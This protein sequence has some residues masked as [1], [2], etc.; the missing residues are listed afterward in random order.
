MAVIFGVKMLNWSKSIL[1]DMHFIQNCPETFT[2]RLSTG[3][4]WKERLVLELN[5]VWNFS[6]SF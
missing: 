4:T 3:H 6:V 5:E 1:W 2:R